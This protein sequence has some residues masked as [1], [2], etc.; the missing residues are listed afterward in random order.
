MTNTFTLAR[1]GAALL[2]L[3]LPLAAAEP[4]LEQAIDFIESQFAQ[5]QPVDRRPIRAETTRLHVEGCTLHLTQRRYSAV[6]SCK[7]ADVWGSAQAFAEDYDEQRRLQLD[8]SAVTGVEYSELLMRL[9]LS[10]EPGH[11]VRES[12][13]AR[14][15]PPN[16][17]EFSGRCQPVP[18]ADQ[19][20]VN[21]D[22]HIGAMNPDG[23][24]L[25][26]AHAF[27]HAA[28]LCRARH[29]EARGDS[30]F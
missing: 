12:V 20:I 23:L 8:L 28:R 14:R 1:L 13:T 17:S 26:L 21:R 10:L 2:C 29:H 15:R 30:P 24:G 5:T 7:A 19:E 3:G 16:T 4:T 9:T 18:Q 22:L 11:T 6:A 27:E 25:R